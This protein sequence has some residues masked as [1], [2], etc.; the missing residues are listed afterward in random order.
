M[1]LFQR[2]VFAWKFGLSSEFIP[3][4]CFCLKIWSEHFKQWIYSKE[5][6]LLENLVGTFADGGEIAVTSCHLIPRCPTLVSVSSFS[7]NITFNLNFNSQP[8]RG[9][10]TWSR[11]AKQK[12]HWQNKEFQTNIFRRRKRH[13]RRVIL[14]D[15]RKKKKIWW[16]FINCKSTREYGNY[17]HTAD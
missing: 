3:K 1:N 15:F 13:I 16:L 5:M 17:I 2:N 4:K 6:F 14:I 10:H 7:I 9:I 11:I 8:N 12:L